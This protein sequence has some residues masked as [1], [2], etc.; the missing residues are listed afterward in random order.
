LVLNT[1]WCC[2]AARQTADTLIK[3]LEEAVNSPHIEEVAERLSFCYTLGLALHG[4]YF[5]S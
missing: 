5:F 1:T 3:R 4:N 2:P